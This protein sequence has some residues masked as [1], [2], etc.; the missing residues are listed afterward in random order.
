MSKRIV[1]I[2]K[3]K[4]KRAVVCLP[5]GS[6]K[7]MIRSLKK[8]YLIN[9]AYGEFFVKL[10]PFLNG[11]HDIVAISRKLSCDKIFVKAAISF[12]FQNGFIE[13]ET[14]LWPS[15]F[16]PE[17]QI[18]YRDNVDFFSE[19]HSDKY[20]FQKELKNS[21]VSLFGF[22]EIGSRILKCLIKLGIGDI[23]II[24]LEGEE[25]KYRD[26]ISNN[27]FVNIEFIRLSDF[28]NNP[29][30]GYKE[31][32]LL[33]A[34]TDIFQSSL[35]HTINE[36]SLIENIRWTS[37]S[38]DGI[39]G[40][41]GPSVYPF[42]TACFECYI[43]WRNIKD[44]CEIELGNRQLGKDSVSYGAPYIFHPY[45]EIIVNLFIIEILRLLINFEPPIT[46]NYEFVFD[47]SIF[48]ARLHRVFKNPRCFKCR[49]E[50][51]L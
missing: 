11:K 12:L 21:K 9:G 1:P 27:P 36:I 15:V 28:I 23:K 8:S 26:F 22:G 24:Y 30:V 13:D 40:R 48:T 6:K 18:L 7:W 34:C 33:I 38:I 20:I 41:I 29:P 5:V 42:E 19:F 43:L 17:E 25:E 49:L 31:R 14:C 47:F 51:S 32:N 4:L 35:Y 39:F 50:N 10:L 45:L 44:G 3:P 16:V 46:Y 37:C 2:C